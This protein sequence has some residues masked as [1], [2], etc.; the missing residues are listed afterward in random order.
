MTSM[1]E[2]DITNELEQTKVDS[3]MDGAKVY[4]GLPGGKGVV[5]SIHPPLPVETKF[6]KKY[7]CQVV[8][9]GSDGN[10]INVGLFLPDQFPLLHPKSNISLILEKYGCNEL[11]ELVGKEV[12]VEESG[13][14]MWKIRV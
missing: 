4:S 1:K 12:E 8:I 9:N 11:R 7:K 2:T 14:M 13:D 3:W 5:G 10:T 6:G